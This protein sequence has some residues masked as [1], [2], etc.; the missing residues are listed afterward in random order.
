[1]ASDVQ[2]L[3]PLLETLARF[4]LVRNLDKLRFYRTIWLCGRGEL[5]TSTTHWNDIDEI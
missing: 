4:D 1:M 5:A 2:T 3:H